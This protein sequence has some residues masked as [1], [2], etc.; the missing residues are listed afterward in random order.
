MRYINNEF[1]NCRLCVEINDFDN[2]LFANKYPGILKKNE[3]FRLK[4]TQVMIPIGPLCYGHLL[5]VSRSHECSFG[6]ADERVIDELKTQIHRVKSYLLEICRGKNIIVFEHGPLSQNER[7]SCCL[8]HAHMNIIPIRKEF[9]VLDNASNI[10][11]FAPIKIDEL[12]RFIQ[13]QKPYI[14]FHCFKEGSFGAI[15]PLGTTQFFR[16]LLKAESPDNTW[17]WRSNAR[18]GIVRLMADSLTLNGF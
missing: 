14:F 5:I 12:G 3:F 13:M 1:L 18:G 6:H 7:G 4:N 10:L 2:S 11:D 17:D 16:K 9:N 15:A 8:I